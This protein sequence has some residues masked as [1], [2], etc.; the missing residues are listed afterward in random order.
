[1][2]FSAIVSSRVV[3]TFFEKFVNLKTKMR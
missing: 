2:A 1:L 3:V